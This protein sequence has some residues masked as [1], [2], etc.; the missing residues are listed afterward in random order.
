MSFNDSSIFKL[1][2]NMTDY[3]YPC[4][5]EY[6]PIIRT[7][8]TLLIAAVIIALPLFL[9]KKIRGEHV[10]NWRDFD[11][12]CMGKGAVVASVLAA[13]EVFGFFACINMGLSVAVPNEDYIAISDTKITIHYGPGYGFFFNKIEAHDVVIPNDQVVT[14]QMK[15]SL[16]TNQSEVRDVIYIEGYKNLRISYKDPQHE[17]MRDVYLDLWQYGGETQIDIHESL[18][19]HFPNY[20]KDEGPLR[21]IRR[22]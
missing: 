17:E 5:A 16:S 19:Q 10:S 20:A 9:R 18:K 3:F 15:E 13:L 12:M 22:I 8:G 14:I 2:T 11:S 4:T 7:L 21:Y 6:S 1:N